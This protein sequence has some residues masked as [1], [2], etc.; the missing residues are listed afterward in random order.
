MTTATYT[1]STP[2]NTVV[3]GTYTVLNQNNIL[4]GLRVEVVE[5]FG[6]NITARPLVEGVRS[7][8]GQ[9]LRGNF[10]CW[11]EDLYL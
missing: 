11:L 3:G 5:V 7:W 2:T 6:R 9:A 10:G 4:H 1:A 8:N